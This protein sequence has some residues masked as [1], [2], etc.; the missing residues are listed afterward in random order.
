MSLRN[1]HP[2][3]KLGLVLVA[4]ATLL[5]FADSNSLL[6]F[7]V[8]ERLTTSPEAFGWQN[9]AAGIGGLA[10]VGAAIWVDRRPPHTIM[11]AGAVAAAFG[12]I[13]VVSNSFPASAL[14]MFVAGVGGSAA[15]SLVFYAIAAKG[16]RRYRGT[17]I[18]ALG[19]VFTL[20][21][22]VG[23][24][25]DWLFDSPML[26]LAVSGA[27]TLAG[28]AVLFLLLP[29][30]FAGSYEPSPT[31]R[32]TLSLP[33][34]RRAA[35]WITAAFFIA[36]LVRAPGQYI[37]FFIARSAPGFEDIKLPF[38]TMP[39][40]SGIGIL[41]WGIASDFYPARRLFLLA[42]LLTLAALAA[43][44]P[45]FGYS[46]S[47]IEYLAF[48]FVSGGLI[49]LPWVLMA[50]L[51]PPRHFAKMAL[52]ISVGGYLG[53]GLGTTL[54]TTVMFFWGSYIA[55]WG[56]D[57]AFWF[58]LAAGIILAIVASRLPRPPANETPAG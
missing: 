57:L 58:F 51:L 39:I 7:V 9:L 20:P 1:L 6:A 30:V 18:G 24:A 11:A 54:L 48:F 2:D 44:R 32:E 19:L 47:A 22:G 27:L 38:Q 16:A 50:E 35:A 5:K 55:V 41:L 8:A 40:F 53:A 37:L 43:F 23:D 12:L 49:C 15:G 36:A 52:G 29:R 28:A 45:F 3:L 56:A 13:V 17:L 46:A 10:I 42:A 33:S 4:A 31:L 25:G 34:V 26:V 21:L 14:G